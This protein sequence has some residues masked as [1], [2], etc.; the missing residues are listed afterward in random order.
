MILVAKVRIFFFNK[1]YKISQFVH[2]NPYRG[3]CAS[4]YF[5]VIIYVSQ[6]TSSLSLINS[7][8][9]PPNSIL[10]LL[11]AVIFITDFAISPL[12]VLDAKKRK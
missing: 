1:V 10:V 2:L 12:A 6:G 9:T 3:G 4:K 11:N 8:H 5:G 7:L